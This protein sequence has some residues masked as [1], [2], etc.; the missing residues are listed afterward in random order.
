LNSA[1][2]A[3]KAIEK[4]PNGADAHVWLGNC[5]KFVSRA[6]EAIS[7]YEKAMRLNPRPPQ[8]YYINL[9]SAYF[10]LGR[11]EDVVPQYEK[12]LASGPN[13]VPTHAGPAAAYVMTGKEDEAR[14]VA[15]E[16]LKIN[17]DFS[18]E[19]FFIPLVIIMFR[20]RNCGI[21]ACNENTFRNRN[22]FLTIPI[23][24]RPTR[25]QKFPDNFLRPCAR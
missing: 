13:S 1:A 19:T 3:E 10:Q 23:K 17:P 21:R 18:A 2:Y 15:E 9:G 22:E 20:K 7:H 25:I 11:Y 8:W 4:D 12:A 6:E 24:Q 16:L 5:L 14:N